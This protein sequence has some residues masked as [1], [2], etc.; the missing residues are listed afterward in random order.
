MD[1][2]TRRQDTIDQETTSRTAADYL[3]VEFEFLFPDHGFSVVHADT[4]PL[5]A[6]SDDILE[7]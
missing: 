5:G 6:S 3:N 7:A 4:W 2:I 1:I